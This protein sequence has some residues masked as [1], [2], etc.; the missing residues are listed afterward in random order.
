[1]DKKN[2]YDASNYYEQIIELGFFSTRKRLEF[3]MKKLFKEIDF[4]N[5][6]VL[7]IGGGIGLAS[8]F[9]AANGAN[10]VTCLEPEFAGSHNKMQLGFYRIQKQLKFLNV[11]L[12]TIPFQD[13]QHTRKYDIV[14]SIN[15]IN[16]LDERSC[17]FIHIDYAAKKIYID[18]FIK[19]YR[20][21]NKGGIVIISDCSRYNFWDL[22]K[23]KN[24]IIGDK[25]NWKIHQSPET[26]AL[27]AKEAGFKKKKI[28]WQS[29][30]RLG[31]TGDL[32]LGN[33][34]CSFFL[35]SHFNLYLQ[36]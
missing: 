31:Y 24:P 9:A 20:M 30:N 33:K 32:F 15:S 10:K 17:K 1:M 16:H 29:F 2:N 36:K 35:L 21:M 12:E 27:L 7:D 11:Y 34:L 19:L 4:K 5:K 6:N 22:M 26:W 28:S 13:Y 3:K 25:I 18:L 14:I 8:F 23:M